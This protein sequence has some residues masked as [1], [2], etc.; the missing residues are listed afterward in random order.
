MTPV[1][2]TAVD[3]SVAV[4][5]LVTSHRQHTMVAKWAKAR[6]LGLS[7]HAL[8]ETYS[9]LTRLPG[10]ARVTA[11]DAVALIDENF[12]ESFQLGARAA[13]AAHR[14][15]ARR[16]IAGGAT[17]DGLVALAARERGAVLFTRDARA[18]STYEALGVSTE[19]LAEP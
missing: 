13:R 15:F 16:G 5:L 7:G 11:A 6:P 1:P 10:D 4:P 19:V 9:V 14:E 18:R 3:T 8:A 12:P 2:L 17:Y